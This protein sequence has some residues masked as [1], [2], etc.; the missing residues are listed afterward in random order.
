MN[1]WIKIHRKFSSWEWADEPRMVSLFVHLLIEASH[2][3]TRWKGQEI[4]R[5][6]VIFGRLK[7]AEKTGISEQGLRTCLKKL[8]LTGEIDIKST[9]KY[10]IVTILNYD[11]YQCRRDRD[12]PADQP[13][14]N[15]QVTSDQPHRKKVKNVKKVKNKENTEPGVESTDQRTDDALF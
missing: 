4:R 2:Q 15:Q 12:Q 6:Q 10:S 8:K 13:T 11:E 5:G 9:N 3:N 7:W 1:G 14:T